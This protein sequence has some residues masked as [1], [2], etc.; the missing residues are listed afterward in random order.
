ARSHRESHR[1]APAQHPAEEHPGRA[2]TAA[3][4]GSVQAEVLSPSAWEVVDRCGCPGA[5]STPPGGRSRSGRDTLRAS[6]GTRANAESGPAESEHASREGTPSAAR[7]YGLMINGT[8]PPAF[9]IRCASAR[10]SPGVMRMQ[11][12]DAAWPIDAGSFVPWM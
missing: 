8:L 7:A 2:R 1:P 4:D 12:R 9:W 10:A 11:P 3:D 6:P 5:A